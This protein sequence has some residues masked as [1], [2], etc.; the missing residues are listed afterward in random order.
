MATPRVSIGLP[1]YNGGNYLR[2]AVDSLLAQ[3]FGDFELIISDNASTDSTPDIAQEY[4]RKDGRVR[5]IR[6]DENRGAAWNFNNVFHLSKGEYFKWSAHD[7]TCAPDFIRKCVDILDSRP[8]VVVCTTQACYLSPDGQPY[9]RPEYNVRMGSARPH[10][11]FH[12]LICIS[13]GCLPVFGLIRRDV[14]A[15]TGLIGA[16]VASDLVLVAELA[17]HGPIHEIPECLLFNRDHADRLTRAYPTAHSRGGWFNPALAGKVIFPT[18]RLLPEF[19]AAI[20]RSPL[21]RRERR[22]CL[23]QLLPWMWKKKKRLRQDL[24]RFLFNFAG[25]RKQRIYGPQAA[26]QPT[27]PASP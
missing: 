22:R 7:D 21:D 19:V 2:A 26:S 10:E 16:Y 27:R 6:S 17:L 25:R 12:D 3:T 24:A 20:K 9:P 11:R 1:V 13:Y 5:Y 18:W 15:R 4:A 23:W 8:E 14:L